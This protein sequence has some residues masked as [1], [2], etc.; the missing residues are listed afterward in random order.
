MSALRH[1]FTPLTLRHRT[2]RARINFG[3]H[4][5][6]MSEARLPGDQHIAYYRE[7]ALGGAGMIVVEPCLAARRAS[8]A[9]YEGRRLA[10]SL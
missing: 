9:I 5:T 4:T 8:L 10:L 6:N 2:L 7:R 1:V 3:A